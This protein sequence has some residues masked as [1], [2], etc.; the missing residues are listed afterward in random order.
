MKRALNVKL[1]ILWLMAVLIIGCGRGAKDHTLHA[2][3]KY[4]CPMHPEIVRDKPG[5]CPVCGM[6]LVP[7]QQHS[8]PDAVDDSLVGLLKPVD[9]QVLATVRTVTALKDEKSDSVVLKGTVNYNTNTQ[10][11]I[12]SRAAG[13]VERLY[14]KYN[15]QPVSRG[16][17]IMDIYS[18]DLQNAMQELLFLYGLK[19]AE[20]IDI[21]KRKL[22]LLGVTGAQI[23]KVLRTGRIDATLSVYSPFDGY[24]TEG[25]QSGQ[26]EGTRGVQANTPVS[27]GSGAMAGSMGNGMSVAPVTPTMP[28]TTAGKGITGLRE[29]Q[30]IAAGQ[31]V[32]SLVRASSLWAEFYADGGALKYLKKG[33]EVS[34]HAVDNPDKATDVKVS[35]VQP[36]YSEGT[37]YTQV[38][39][40]IDNG[41]GRW[42]VGEL[43][44]VSLY[45]AEVN[46]TWL[47]KTA[48][49]QLGTRFAAFVKQDKVFIP[50][51]VTVYNSTGGWVN[52]GDSMPEG[53]QF[54]VNA[55]FLVDS[56]S[57]IKAQKVASR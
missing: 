31:A 40:A 48:V 27:A 17:K 22:H 10:T 14:I 1:F 12:A 21:A 57:F 41:S 35:L 49:V 55:W 15:Y 13:R 25:I 37:Q 30:Y 16:E 42:K 46:G 47:P 18:P 51:Y 56:E 38:R 52:I 34:V 26:R 2:S 39:A 43:V 28:E 3:G 4:T 32:F 11:V 9:E 50:H 45:G 24:V 8:S 5:K 19:D 53:T 7:V 36:F 33:T 20:R 29:G 6:D 54:A 23:N 44:Q